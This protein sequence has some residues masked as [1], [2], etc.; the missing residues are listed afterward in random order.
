[1]FCGKSSVTITGSELQSRLSVCFDCA[2]SLSL[3][4]WLNC[5]WHGSRQHI[6]STCPNQSRNVWNYKIPDALFPKSLW[7]RW[8]KAESYCRRAGMK[9]FTKWLKCTID[10]SPPFLCR[11]L[12]LFHYQN[13]ILSRSGARDS[14]ADQSEVRT[15]VNLLKAPKQVVVSV[16]GVFRDA[17]EWWCDSGSGFEVGSAGGL[18]G[19]R[20]RFGCLWRDR[21]QVSRGF[22]KTQEEVQVRLVFSHCDWFNDPSGSGRLVWIYMGLLISVDELQVCWPE[23]QRPRPPVASRGREGENTTQ[24]Q[25]QNP[26]HTKHTK[27]E[28]NKTKKKKKTQSYKPHKPWSQ[29]VGRDRSVLT[30]KLQWTLEEPLTR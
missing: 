15:R 4:Y 24:G 7:T 3:Q 1:M 11:T 28:Q 20:L 10:G 25:T 18:A 19:F 9:I 5:T 13:L 27:R 8:V 23:L 21:E 26:K 12:V 30:I 17:G 6:S 16:A 29:P 14:N 22:K 2:K